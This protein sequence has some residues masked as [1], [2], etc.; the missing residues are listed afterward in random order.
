MIWTAID[1]DQGL[2][3]AFLK[4]NGASATL[5]ILVEATDARH[6]VVEVFDDT[7]MRVTASIEAQTAE[8]A[9]AWAAA[10][11]AGWAFGLWPPPPEALRYRGDE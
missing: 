3:K 8:H 11:T 1:H 2:W 5:M 7:L 6:Y 4:Y 9:K 10:F